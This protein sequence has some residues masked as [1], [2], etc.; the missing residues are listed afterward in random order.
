VTF[1]VDVEAV[2]SCMIF[3]ACYETREIDYGHK[4]SFGRA[5]I[6]KYRLEGEEEWRYGSA[7]P[8]G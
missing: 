2:F 5:N 3:E 8:E 1:V 7:I 4:D 6:P